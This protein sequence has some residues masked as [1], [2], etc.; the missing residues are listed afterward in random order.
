MASVKFPTFPTIDLSKLDLGTLPKIELPSFAWPAID[1]DAVAKAAKDAAYIAVGLAVLA[2]QKAQVRRHE[3]IAA[4][5]DQFG[6]GKS[7]IESLVQA[8]ETQFSGLDSRLDAIETKIDTGV[9]NL[10]KRLPEK[11]GA[12]L[13]QAHDT[14]KAARKQV[15]G[16]LT[17]VA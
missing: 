5:N 4:G 6:L 14:A 16:L 10:E 13:G 11:V 8:F 15:R 17:Q 1:T 2:Y 3:M 12:L 7:Q 9:A